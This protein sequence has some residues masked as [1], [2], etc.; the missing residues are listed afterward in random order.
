M[1]YLFSILGYPF[2]FKMKFPNQNSTVKF[3]YLRET[4][5]FVFTL[6]AKQFAYILF[7][8]VLNCKLFSYNWIALWSQTPN[9]GTYRAPPRA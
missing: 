2:Q 3:Y 5:K 7:Q 8:K 9:R 6:Q 4:K 1:N